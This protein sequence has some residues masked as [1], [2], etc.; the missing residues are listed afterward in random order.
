MTIILLVVFV[1]AFALSAWTILDPQAAIR[2]R[3]RFKIPENLLTGG[4]F[5]STPKIARITAS[6]AALLCLFAIAELV[7]R[8][9]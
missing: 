4:I 6:L 3:R 9:F 8:I 1:A 5:Y 7:R 2:F